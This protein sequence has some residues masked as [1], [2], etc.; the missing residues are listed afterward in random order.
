MAGDEPEGEGR[1]PYGDL[2]LQDFS[3]GNGG[4]CVTTTMGSGQEL[5]LS[6][7]MNEGTLGVAKAI[8]IIVEQAKDVPT[9][10]ARWSMLQMGIGAEMRGMRLTSK[11]PKASALIKREFGV[12]R[13]MTTEKTGIAFSLLLELAEMKNKESQTQTEHGKKRKRSERSHSSLHQY[14][15]DV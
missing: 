5:I 12:R 15:G 10:A 2:K 6:Q 14:I 11:A 7:C 4:Y 3:D 9:I 13:N 1:E 8:D